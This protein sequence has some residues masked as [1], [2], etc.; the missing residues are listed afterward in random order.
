[1]WRCGRHAE[2][3]RQWGE[4]HLPSAP[5]KFWHLFMERLEAADQ[6]DLIVQ[7]LPF[8]DRTKVSE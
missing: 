2:A 5:A 6:L 4:A 7:W 3:V 8:N 1:M